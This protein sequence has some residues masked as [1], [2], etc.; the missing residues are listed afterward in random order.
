MA[1]LQ[2]FKIWIMNYT[3]KTTNAPGIFTLEDENGNPIADVRGKKLA[4][5]FAALPEIVSA[6]YEMIDSYQLEASNENSSLLNAR[7]VLL[8]IGHEIP[9]IYL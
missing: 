9:T 4:A 2:T 6:L 3:I 8:K 5:Q 7:A 1:D